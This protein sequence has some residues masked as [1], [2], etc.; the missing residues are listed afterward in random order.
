MGEFLHSAFAKRLVIQHQV[1]LRS[2]VLRVHQCGIS[3]LGGC[4]GLYHRRDTIEPKVANGSLEPLIAADLDLVNMIGIA[5][6][7][8]IRQAL[9]THFPGGFDL[10]RVATPVRLRY[11]SPH[12]RIVKVCVMQLSEVIPQVQVFEQTFVFLFLFVSSSGVS[13]CHVHFSTVIDVPVIM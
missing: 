4:E 5:E 9:R 10:D 7:P 12:Q 6:W 8:C 1:I 2:K 11:L 3:Q 13:R